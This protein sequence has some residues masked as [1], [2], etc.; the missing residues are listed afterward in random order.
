MKLSAALNLACS[1]LLNANDLPAQPLKIA[2][3][4][5]EH[6]SGLDVASQI[7]M[8]DSELGKDVE[9]KFFTAL[10]AF[11]AGAVLEYITGKASFYSKDFIVLENV[12]VPRPETE[13]LVDMGLKA[14]KNIS[15]PKICE[16]GVGSGVVSICLALK[17]PD[18]KITA[19]D[20]SET[21]LKNAELNANKFKVKLDLVK[22]DLLDKMG[23]SFDMLISNPPYISRSYKLDSRV[24]NEPHEALFGGDVGDELIKKL[25][26]QASQRGIKLLVCEIG[27]DQ[28]Q[29]LSKALKQA[30][31][32]AEFYQDLAG[33]ERGF[34]A[35]LLK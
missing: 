24:L 1:Q 6:A 19:C 2:R 4:L 14:I 20:I 18:A 32:E 26:H 10:K 21:A 23:S 33:F 27:F 25:I 15:S 5:L 31:Y 13:I 11:L 8:A 16:V 17:R 9:Q 29:S 28:K 35:R 12:L 34:L 3:I 22:S 7:L 30:G